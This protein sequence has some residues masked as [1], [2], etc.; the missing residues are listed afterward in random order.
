MTPRRNHR[1]LALGALVA[2]LTGC[3]STEA[4]QPALYAPS[5]HTI[6]GRVIDVRPEDNLAVIAIEPES[7]WPVNTVLVARDHSLQPTAML[8]SLEPHNDTTAAA[9][10]LQGQPKRLDTLVIPTKTLEKKAAETLTTRP[11]T[12]E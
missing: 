12:A 4:P 5:P 8:S 6:V 2:T 3:A 7:A 1:S 9:H 11:T 10:I